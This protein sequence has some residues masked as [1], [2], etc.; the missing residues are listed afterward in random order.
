MLVDST[1]L[2][3]RGRRLL[4]RRRA[5]PARS[6]ALEP[7]SAGRRRPRADPRRAS[8]SAAERARASR[9][10]VTA[11]G[12]RRRVAQTAATAG[13]ARPVGLDRLPLTRAARERRAR[14]ADA[15]RRR[16][17]R[18]LEPDDLREGDHP[19]RRLRRAAARAAS[20]RAEREGALPRARLRRCRRR[21][22]SA[23]PGLGA[24][25]AGATATSRSRSTPTSPTTR[26]PSTRRPSGC[27]SRSLA[28]TSSSRSRRPRP[29]SRRSRTRSPP[30]ARSTSR[31]SS[32]SSATSPSRAPTSTGSTRFRADGRRR[33]DVHSVASFFVS[34]VDSETDRRLDALGAPPEL[35]G[36]LG[37]ANAKLAYA[38]YRELF[39]PD[40]ELWAELAAAGA[41]PQRCLWASTST[42]NP[43]YRDVL[44]VEELIGPETSTPCPRQTLLAFQDHGRVAPTLERGL[45]EAHRLLERLAAAGVDY[46][47]VVE[48]LEAEGIEKF[49]GAF[50][51][52]SPGWRRSGRRC[53]SDR[54][55]SDEARRDQRLRADRPQLLPRLPGA[56]SRLR[57]R[58]RQRSRRREDDGAPARVRLDPRPACTKTSTPTRT[59]SA[60]ASAGCARFRSPTLQKLPWR[61]LDIDVVV[62]ATGASRSARRRRRTLTPAPAGRDL[63]RGER[64]R[65]DARLRRQRRRLRPR[66]S[67]DRLER[68]LHN[69]LCHAAGEGAP[70]RVQDRAR[71]HDDR[72]RVHG[73]AAPARRA[74]TRICAARGPL[75]ST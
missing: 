11:E 54:R 27:T 15:R 12:L 70:R 50:S 37:I 30:A 47:D 57:D 13:R 35:K 69:E 34:R 46:D 55:C 72:A 19:R 64:R 49:S 65:R 24:D 52:C 20:A 39:S 45:D 73:H 56:P 40:D 6:P 36:K 7:A 58:R 33:R 41:H 21:L 48:T 14:A 29:A 75:R 17:R 1:T 53:D 25:A 9:D 3:R 59:R 18:D 28:R 8:R 5:A 38:R 44:Y 42:K 23:A 68:L 60:S 4:P 61:E 67:S 32:R 63:G 16:R 51:R 71:L 66:A 62:E 2:A 74:R 22:R 26:P 31:S 43:A 10:D